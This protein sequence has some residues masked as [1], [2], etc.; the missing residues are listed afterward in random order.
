MAFFLTP[1]TGSD[2]EPLSWWLMMSWYVQL[3]RTLENCSNSRAH[4][5]GIYSDYLTVIRDLLGDLLLQSIWCCEWKASMGGRWSGW[6][7]FIS[8]HKQITVS[9]LLFCC[10]CEIEVDK[11]SAASPISL[12]TRTQSTRK[13]NPVQPAALTA[14][15]VNGR[16]RFLHDY[17]QTEDITISEIPLVLVFATSLPNLKP[18]ICWLSKSRALIRTS[19]QLT[20]N[21]NTKK[22]RKKIT[23]IHRVSWHQTKHLQSR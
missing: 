6:D 14:V 16:M 19:R 13:P 20:W 1:E 11:Q 3:A 18:Q 9:A 15:N 8:C 5:K 23:R 17:P 22:I 4:A 2:S 21:L 12:I 10:S 7:D